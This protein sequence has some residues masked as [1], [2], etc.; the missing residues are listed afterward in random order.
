MAQNGL[1]PVSLGRH[2]HRFWRRF[3]SFDFARTMADCPVV[4]AEIL[5]A[6]ATFPITF[7]KSEHGFYP[8][9]V[10]SVQSDQPT[11][12][13]SAHGKWLATYVPSVLRCA[14]FRPRLIEPDGDGR[15]ELLVDET[16]G[17]ITDNPED[18]TFFDKSGQLAPEL[19]KVAAFFR[20]L[21]ESMKYTTHLC[22]VLADMGLFGPLTTF[23]GVEFPSG[24][25]GVTQNALEKI[26]R[27]H[28][29]LLT[30]NGGLRLIHAHQ[31]SLTHSIWLT[32]AH[33]RAHREA[34]GSLT[35][36]TT[37]VSGFL[38]AL[39]AAQQKEEA[40]DHCRQEGHHAF[41]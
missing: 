37:G 26:P 30:S 32:H 23:Q 10:L 34:D 7:R 24:H 25:F 12:F 9:A 4:E 29:S 3:T 36:Q 35:Q 38:D 31:I 13:V 33:A 16:A 8:V 28:L 14:P 22:R 2:G 41:L 17:L 21:K 39:V 40:M 6:A 19:K 11:P 18:E 27:A 20:A 1:T 5:Q 15:D